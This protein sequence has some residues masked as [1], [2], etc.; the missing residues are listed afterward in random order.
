MRVTT[1]IITSP[2]VVSD[3]KASLA[4]VAAAEVRAEKVRLVEAGDAELGVDVSV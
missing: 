1:A 3:G 2:E 4:A